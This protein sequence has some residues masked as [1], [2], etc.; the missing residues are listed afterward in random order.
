MCVPSAHVSCVTGSSNAWPGSSAEMV[1]LRGIT[2]RCIDFVLHFSFSGA[3]PDGEGHGT[4]QGT[5][6]VATCV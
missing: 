1:R 6:R 5:A 2:D 3:Q 4:C